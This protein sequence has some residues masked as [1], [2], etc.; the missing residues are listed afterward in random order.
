ACSSS[1]SPACSHS[2]KRK[3]S[4]RKPMRAMARASPGRRPSTRTL[5]PPGRTSPRSILTAVLFPAPLG[6]RKPD[7]SPLGTSGARSDAAPDFHLADA[8]H[9]A[10]EGE[11][12]RAAPVDLAAEAPRLFGAHPDHPQGGLTQCLEP[13]AGWELHGRTQPLVQRQLV[14]PAPDARLDR[15]R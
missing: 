10:G 5:P 9:G 7:T 12:E 15:R 8:L 1:S 6:P 2:W 11:E 3:C 13:D 4:G 14:G